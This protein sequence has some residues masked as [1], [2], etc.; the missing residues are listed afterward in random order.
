MQAHKP[1]PDGLERAKA[2]ITATATINFQPSKPK[3][4]PPARHDVQSPR[5]MAAT[6]SRRALSKPSRIL[7]TG[8]FATCRRRERPARASRKS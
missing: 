4:S 3:A 5:P 8:I 6:T 7:L 2:K 1:I